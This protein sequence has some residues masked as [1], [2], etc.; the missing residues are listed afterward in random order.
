VK[1]IY[2]DMAALQRL[3]E[4]YE[5]L[6]TLRK[7]REVLDENFKVADLKSKILIELTLS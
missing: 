4:F 6:K 1:A 2:I 3:N 5:L 7:V